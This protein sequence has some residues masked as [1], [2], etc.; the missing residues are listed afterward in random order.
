MNNRDYSTIIFWGD[1]PYG[2][3]RPNI[4]G[5]DVFVHR[6]EGQKKRGTPP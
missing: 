5:R 1:R 4:G 6:S 2:F 3:I